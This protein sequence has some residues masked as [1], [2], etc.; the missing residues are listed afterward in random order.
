M[1]YQ[2]ILE[3]IVTNSKSIS[4]ISLPQSVKD[5][6][7]VIASKCLKQKGVYTVTVTLL[8]YKTQHPEQ[9]IRFHQE[10]QDNGFSGRSFDTLYVTP[11]LKKL[12]LPSMAESGWLTRSLEQPYPYML[13]YNGKISG[14]CKQPFLQTLDYVQKNP[15]KALEMLRYLLNKVLIVV[16]SNKVEIKPLDNPENLT[17]DLIISALDKHFKT[18]YGTHNGAKLPVLAFY[19]IYLSIIKEVKRYENCSLAPLASLTACDLTSKASGDVEI[20]KEDKLF[21]SVEIKLDKEIDSTIVRV[22]E[23]K[24]YRF[25]PTRYYILSYYGIKEEDHIEI[26]NIVDQVQRTHGCQIIIN[27]LIPTIKYYL[28]LIY[29]L[30][31]F[32]EN[33]CYL[34]RN[35]RELQKIHK[36]TLNEI[37][38]TILTQNQTISKDL[39]S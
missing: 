34:V 39:F 23:E 2:A 22:V 25:N 29:N 15:W 28:R 38:G 1:K 33:Y 17:I 24:I 13:N 8:F 30:S 31:D 14:G 10:Q 27:G 37:I 9:D 12:G 35:D 6:L 18:K 26:K 19:A 16:E 11:T 4:D 21:E 32:W 20:F 36:E 3:Q 7:D 5:N